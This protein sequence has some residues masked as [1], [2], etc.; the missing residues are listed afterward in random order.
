MVI[1]SIKCFFGFVWPEVAVNITSSHSGWVLIA[2]RPPF[3][4]LESGPAIKLWKNIL[5]SSGISTS[6]FSIS[7][8]FKSLGNRVFL[9]GIRAII[10]TFPFK[11]LSLNSIFWPLLLKTWMLNTLHSLFLILSSPLCFLI[12]SS[13]FCELEVTSMNS[14]PPNS[15]SR[16][17]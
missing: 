2:F 14:Y 3:H 11:S 15:V 1:P 10:R 4:R 9:Q 6:P 13:G 8:N 17:W 12:L 7:D 5:I 16:C